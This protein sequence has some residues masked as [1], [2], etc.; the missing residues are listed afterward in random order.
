MIPSGMISLFS[1][2]SG[3]LIYIASMKMFRQKDF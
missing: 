2:E 1:L 3:V